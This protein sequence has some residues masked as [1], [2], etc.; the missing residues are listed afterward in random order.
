[1]VDAFGRAYRR[2]VK[3]GKRG[4]PGTPGIN[5]LSSFMPKSLVNLLQKYDEEC[6]FTLTDLERD[7]QEKSVD[8]INSRQDR[9]RDS[10]HIRY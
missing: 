1:M 4:K 3:N 10:D 5:V 9:P 7:I 2:G 6:C 8:H